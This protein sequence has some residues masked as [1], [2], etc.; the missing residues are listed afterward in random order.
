MI[1]PSNFAAI[2]PYLVVDDGIR[3]VQ[4]LVEGLGGVFLGQHLDDAGRIRNAQVRFHNSTIMLSDSSDMIKATTGHYVLYVDDV[5]QSTEKA[6]SAGAELI[7][8]AIEQPYG[9]IQAG[10]KDCANNFWWITQR[11]SSEPYF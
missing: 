11:V 9:D 5:Y 1:L 3:Y 2:S 4:F 8:A 6:I 7:Q 10:V